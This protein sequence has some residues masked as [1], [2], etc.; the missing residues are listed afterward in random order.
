MLEC[1]HLNYRHPEGS[2]RPTFSEVLDSLLQ[3]ESEL[4]YWKAIM[5]EGQ[6]AEG[7]QQSSSSSAE[8]AILGAPLENG[9]KLYPELQRT[10]MY[11]SM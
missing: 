2:C 8:A 7:S 9:E 11:M 1:I 10:Y 5:T 6:L 4:L 3:P